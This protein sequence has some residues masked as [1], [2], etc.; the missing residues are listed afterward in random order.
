MAWQNIFKLCLA[1]RPVA[2]IAGK[3]IALLHL[4]CELVAELFQSPQQIR[5]ADMQ[6]M[7][8]EKTQ[9]EIEM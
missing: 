6:S 5:I 1:L 7:S 4:S 2:V 9:V 8:H 3:G